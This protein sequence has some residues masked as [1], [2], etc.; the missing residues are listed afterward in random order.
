MIDSGS[1][2]GVQFFKKEF[3][4]QTDS[5]R[6][7]FS[8]ECRHIVLGRSIHTGFV[9]GIVTSDGREDGRNVR[10]GSSNRTHVV[11]R[12]RKWNYAPG[13]NPSIRGF[14]ADHTA[15]RGRLP[16]RAGGI[17]TD[18]AVTQFSGNRGG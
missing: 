16:D 1:N 11:Q 7:K 15:Q 13:A 6:R 10:N 3:P 12:N 8:S 2:F 18:R 9:R 14:Q 17:S 4:W 5:K